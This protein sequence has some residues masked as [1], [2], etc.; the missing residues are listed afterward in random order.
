MVSR[1]L[2]T[3]RNTFI[4]LLACATIWVWIGLA[5]GVNE[6][7]LGDSLEQFIWAQSF[8]WGYWKHPPLSTWLLYGAL[9]LFGPSYL[10]T[11]LLS[12]VLY[13][14][15]LVATYKIAALLFN[16][17]RA[18]WVVL[19]LTLHYGF[20]RRAQLY[21]HNSVLVA[22]IAMTV[23]TTLLALRK[24]SL[25]LWFVCG[26][27][28]GLSILVKYQAIFPLIGIFVA[29][30][31]THQMGK[32]KRGLMVACTTGLL[33]LTPHIYWIFESQ[34]QTIT[35]ALNYVENSG[36]SSRGER[37]GAFFV[38]QFRYYLP[39]IFFIGLLWAAQYVNPK[40]V[41]AALPLASDQRSWLIGLI[42]IPLGVLLFVSLALG[43]RL[44]GHWGLQTTQ[45][46]SIGV[47]YWIFN[48]YGSLDKSKFFVWLG[49]QIIA[50]AIFLAQGVGLILYANPALAVRELPAKQ[51]SSE[52]MKFWQSKTQ[53]PLIYISGDGSMS[54]MLAAYSG[55]HL[56]VLEDGDYKKSPWIQAASLEK[57]GYLQVFVSDEAVS[58][59][60]TR[61]I[62]YTLASHDQSHEW[63]RTQYL[64]LKYHAPLKRC[65]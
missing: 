54:A 4:L 20:T 42:G 6:S 18:I 46:L 7:Q 48:K 17:E 2:S 16:E 50:I 26:L 19:L 15:T 32:S 8:E 64:S 58:D 25:W 65:D 57:D 61:S 10:W 5:I 3:H 43:V 9:H 52:A 62:P 14:L 11:Y 29:I 36:F 53:C 22:F 60:D 37:Q 31:L 55:I 39:M 12:G 51:L 1:L 41:R 38:T 44:Q 35:Y 21:N 28:G 63:P 59:A 47:A 23:W 40:K 13:T 30:A 49:V 56:K 45:F 34:F 24:Q 33:V 27:L